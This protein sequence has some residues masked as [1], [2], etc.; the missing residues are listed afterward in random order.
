MRMAWELRAGRLGIALMGDPESERYE[1]VV[2]EREI[3]QRILEIDQ[4]RVLFFNE[5]PPD[6]D[7][8]SQ[9]LY[10]TD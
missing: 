6:S 2:I 4:H 7:D 3:V 5:K 1:Y 9:R 8:P 10:G